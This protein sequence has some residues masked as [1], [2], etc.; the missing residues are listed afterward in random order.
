MTTE[1]ASR[2]ETAAEAWVRAFADA[3]RAP[4]DADAFADQLEPWLD[5]E[6][7][8]VQPQMPTLTGLRAFRERFARPLFALVPDLH[9]VVDGFAARGDVV[10]V[11]LRLEGTLGRRLTMRSVDRVVLRAGRAVERVAHLDPTPL[12]LAVASEAVGLV[13]PR[14]G[15]AAP[16]TGARSP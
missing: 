2:A 7:R 11:E 3:W 16:V 14:V 15:R 12:L 6:V 9:G 1:T 8:L 4:S 10:Y 13:A 5:P